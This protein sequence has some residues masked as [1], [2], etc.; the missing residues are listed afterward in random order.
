M[1]AVFMKTWLC[2]RLVIFSLVLFLILIAGCSPRSPASP[3]PAS[4]TPYGTATLPFSGPPTEK[5]SSPI[6]GYQPFTNIP[7][8]PTKSV[9]SAPPPEKLGTVE[10]DIEY[11]NIN[12]YSLKL[13]MY[14]PKSAK[15]AVPAVIY[16]HGGGWT[17]GDKAGMRKEDLSALLDRGYLVA[18]IN[19]RLAPQYKFPAQIEDVKQAVRFLR[20]NASRFGLDPT[21]IGAWG[22]SAGGHLVALLGTCDDADFSTGP[23]VFSVSGRVQAVVDWFGPADLVNMAQP[24]L[25]AQVFGN[26]AVLKSASPITYV[27]SDDPP[28]LIMHGDQDKT[29]PLS[30]S[31]TLYQKLQAAVVPSQLVVVKN[32]GHS[33]IP[34]G[35]APISPTLSQIAIIMADFFDKY[36][37]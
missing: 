18:S 10:R 27:S 35:T 24:N 4:S 1:G 19:Y 32:A 23:Y 2:L 3:P 7:T 25:I 29:V 31:E 20:A 5:P 13:D 26:E 9:L 12:G 17:S 36:L 11:A 8:N 14:Y 22:G 21:R 28:F 30:Q 6:P 34:T 15:T 33:F 16:V 37:K